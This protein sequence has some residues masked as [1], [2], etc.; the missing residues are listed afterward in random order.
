MEPKLLVL[1]YFDDA[2][3]SLTEII[4]CLLISGYAAPEVLVVVKLGAHNVV[5]LKVR[6]KS[7]LL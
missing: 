6:S 5:D 4:W 7:H 1:A 3:S 2:T